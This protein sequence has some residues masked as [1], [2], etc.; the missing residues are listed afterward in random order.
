[1][2]TTAEEIQ[3]R[4]TR[5]SPGDQRQVLDFVQELQ[6]I[7]EI[8]QAILSLP[9]SP[10]PEAKIPAS[11]LFGFKLPL[12]VVEEIERA[13]QDCERVDIDEW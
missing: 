5:L 1:M 10:L 13:L 7:S 9:K 11:A 8:H 6:E 4:I 12:E 2:A 3:A